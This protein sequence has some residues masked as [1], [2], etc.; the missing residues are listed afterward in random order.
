MRFFTFALS[1]FLAGG[2]LAQDDAG[3]PPINS[4]RL[5][6]QTSCV[7][8]I[9]SASWSPDGNWI[10][11]ADGGGSIKIWE[12]QSG[13]QLL[14]IQAGSS[15]NL[16][17]SFSPDG[18]KILASVA[19]TTQLA[20]DSATGKPLKAEPLKT[21]SWLVVSGSPP[22]FATSQ[23]GTKTAVIRD[24]K[25]KLGDSP[26]KDPPVPLKGLHGRVLSAVLSSNGAFLVTGGADKRCAIWDVGSGTQLKSVAN[27]WPVESVSIS[28]DEKHILATAAD[29][30]SLVWD[31]DSG[32]VVAAIPKLSQSGSGSYT[33]KSSFSPDGSLALIAGD[34]AVEIW[35]AMGNNQVSALVG[36]TRVQPA[37]L[38]SLKP[39]LENLTHLSLAG[40]KLV[41]YRDGTIKLSRINGKKELCTMFLFKDASWAVVDPSNRYDGSNGGHV[42]GLHW[43]RNGTSPMGLDQLRFAYY[44]PGLLEKILKG[45]KLPEIPK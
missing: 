26:A 36:D 40:V 13:F 33:A 32:K 34:E 39:Q 42:G 4:L 15:P 11:T 18:R 44:T 28:A 30:Q 23:D 27:P 35:K 29:G 19:G 41:A 6:A 2:A 22:V 25:L 16:Q 43:V 14:S 5:V 24:G 10:L 7:G 20:W 1:G 21:K 9:N 37:A 3:P 45:Q 8:G 17:A 12:A 31:V 38:A